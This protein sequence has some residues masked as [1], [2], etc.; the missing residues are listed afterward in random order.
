MRRIIPLAAAGVLAVLALGPRGAD[1]LTEFAAVRALAP[2]QAATVAIG[3]GGELT[4]KD[5]SWQDG[6]YRVRIGT[7]V[8]PG[9]VPRLAFIGAAAA[10]TGSVSANDVSIDT[11]TTIYKIK[12]IDVTG[13]AL[14]TADLAAL[15]DQKSPQSVSER[16]AGLTA[17]AIMIPEILAEATLGAVTQKI[18]YR[19]IRFADIVQGKSAQASAA[20]ASFTA[21]D[22][23]AG[24]I[25]GAYGPMSATNIDLVLATRMFAEPRRDPAETKKPLYDRFTIEALKLSAPKMRLDFS[26]GILTA[27]DVKGRALATPIGAIRAPSE[28]TA[29]AG[30]WR[31]MVGALD[32]GG[33]EAKNITLAV[34]PADGDHVEISLGRAYLNGF[35][36]T[37]LG[38]LGMDHLSVASG[39][40]KIE[41][42]SVLVHDLDFKAT[43]DALDTA[44][45]ASAV[46]ARAALPAIGQ[47]VMAGLAVDIPDSSKTG[48]SADGARDIFQVGRLELNGSDPQDGIPTR[49]GALLDHLTFML[50]PSPDSTFKPLL[51][52]GYNNLDLSSRL[53]AHWNETAQELKIEDL[54]LS[55]AQMGSL[56][57]SG[58]FTNVSKDLFS[59]DP[60]SAQAAALS[61]LWTQV[62]LKVANHGIF[63]KAI[64]VAAKN[65]GMTADDLKQRYVTIAAA[66]VP[67]MLDNA[68]GAKAIGAALAKF[69]ASPKSLRITA[70]STEGIGASDLML[71]NDP[72][73]L[74]KRL[75]IEAA[76]NE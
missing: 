66:V 35:S 73:T 76:A 55:G 10:Q 25:Q 21:N 64:A 51:D 44:G 27:H 57:V 7:L 46:D 53:A 1:M 12:R 58:V 36:D 60:A 37:L 9:P 75:D 61:A 43:R 45:A 8:L 47:F 63:E 14:S 34:T 2:L 28:P 42:A 22:A 33:A 11:G 59:R 54:S 67:A 23:K 16:C 69:I 5:L 50:P 24:T 41:A 6:D 39:N 49:F 52:M 13:T 68:P 3:R 18:V 40:G 31:D 29:A 72:G 30:I 70:R 19:D 15:L 74:L 38:D 20:G 4:F 26:I 32:V 56:E 17:G 65:E 48:N 62:E 71:L